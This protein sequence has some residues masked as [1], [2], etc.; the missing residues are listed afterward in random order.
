MKSKPVTIMVLL[1]FLV[2]LASEAQLLQMNTALVIGSGCVL[3]ALALSV[4][5]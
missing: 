3:Y 1:A 4:W 2:T 5:W